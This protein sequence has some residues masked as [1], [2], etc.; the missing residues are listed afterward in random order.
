ML[1]WRRGSQQGKTRGASGCANGRSC[2]HVQTQKGGLSGAYRGAH[3]PHRRGKRRIRVSTEGR[4][5]LRSC[6]KAGQSSSLRKK[7]Q[8]W[9]GC[10][11][12]DQG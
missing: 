5:S 6:R 7:N 4:G 11:K 10:A 12:S 1:R 9:S 3:N 2:C 8:R